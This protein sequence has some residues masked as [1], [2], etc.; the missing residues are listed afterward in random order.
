MVSERVSNKDPL[1]IETVV[2]VYQNEQ[3]ELVAGPLT[4]AEL[5][6]KLLLTKHDI[7]N[8]SDLNGLRAI[9]TD[10]SPWQSHDLSITISHEQLVEMPQAY[11][12]D[13]GN[14]VIS[15]DVPLPVNRPLF[16][17]KNV[18]VGKG[19]SVDQPFDLFEQG[20]VDYQVEF[21][22]SSTTNLRFFSIKGVRCRLES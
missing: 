1:S 20:I 17:L 15:N 3:I 5:V 13:D 2:N 6:S 11:F 8:G 22:W 4:I 19:Q 18:K 12:S 16:P 21:H 10:D 7:T 14:E 9:L